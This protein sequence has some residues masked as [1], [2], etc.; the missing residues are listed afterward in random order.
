VTTDPTLTTAAGALTAMATTSLPAGGLP[1]NPDIF[2]RLHAISELALRVAPNVG[3]DM[4]EVALANVGTVDL[5][6]NL[7]RDAALDLAMRLTGAVMRLKQ[8]RP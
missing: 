7:D 1:G 3:L 2:A 6:L 4:V 8:A 5:R